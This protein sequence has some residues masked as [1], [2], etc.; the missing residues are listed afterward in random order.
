MNFINQGLKMISKNKILEWFNFRNNPWNLLIFSIVILVL[1]FTHTRCTSVNEQSR[2]SLIESFLERGVFYTDDSPYRNFIDTVF[3]QGHFY[4]DK[5]PFLSLFSIAV[6]FLAHF[7]IK[8]S[9]PFGPSVLYYLATT[10][11]NGFCLFAIYYFM[12]KAFKMF[13]IPDS[14]AL[15]TMAY[16]FFGS[17]LLPFSTVYNS[18]IPEAALIF[19]SFY[20]VLEYGF[21]KN[22]NSPF[23]SGALLGA[24][25]CIHVVAGSIFAVLSGIYFLSRSFKG[26]LRF[27]GIFA[28]FFLFGILINQI[29]HGDPKPFY[30]MPE[31]YIYNRSYWISCKQ[32]IPGVT[33]EKLLKR[34]EEL[35]FSFMKEDVV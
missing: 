26:F 28:I 30:L 18:H 5:Q 16:L 23:F 12:R 31:T 25:L 24:S 9:T 34:C 14:A 19:A 7:F 35:K 22:K 13:S 29:E 1:F 20:Y 2:F 6:L 21:F 3:F 15:L 8:F 32:I 4:S 33:K 11:L 17:W 27:V 10:T